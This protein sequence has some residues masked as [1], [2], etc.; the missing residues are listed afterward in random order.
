MYMLHLRS[1]GFGRGR[2]GDRGDRGDRR[3][4]GRGRGRGDKV[5]DRVT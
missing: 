3:G 2:R 1:G 5:K 4:R